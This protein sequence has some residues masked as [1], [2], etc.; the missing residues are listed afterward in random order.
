MYM[1]RINL[2]P[3]HY[4]SS[5]ALYHDCKTYTILSLHRD[6]PDGE[7]KVS[8]FCPVLASGNTTSPYCRAVMF[9]P[10]AESRL[11]RVDI[12]G[13]NINAQKRFNFTIL[14]KLD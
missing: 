6:P 9:K 2:V 10:K 14:D 4:S 8:G 11:Q 13:L 7:A 12:K 3:R 5:Q 1:V